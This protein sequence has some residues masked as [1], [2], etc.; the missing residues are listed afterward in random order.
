MSISDYEV[1]I[2]LEVHAELSTKTKIFS[3]LQKKFVPHQKNIYSQFLM[4][5]PEN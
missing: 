5:I 1:V 4:P 3:N 2:G